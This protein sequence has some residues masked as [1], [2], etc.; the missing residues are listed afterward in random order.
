MTKILKKVQLSIIIRKLTIICLC[1]WHFSCMS[2][3][4]YV[5]LDF[6]QQRYMDAE[7]VIP[8]SSYDVLGDYYYF[9]KAPELSNVGKIALPPSK[10]C[11]VY[12]DMTK[13]YTFWSGMGR[14]A[15]RQE[16]ILCWMGFQEENTDQEQAIRDAL[17]KRYGIIMGKDGEQG[18]PAKWFT[19]FLEMVAL[20]QYRFGLWIGKHGGIYSF[21][22]GMLEE[23]QKDDIDIW[24]DFEWQHNA[25]D[26]SLYDRS[27]EFAK[28]LSGSTANMAR[29]ALLLLA[30]D[31]MLAYPQHDD[32]HEVNEEIQSLP[33]YVWMQKDGSLEMSVLGNKT[34]T[35][36]QKREMADLRQAFQKLPKFT[37][38]MTSTLHGLMPGVLLYATYS[39]L[40]WTFSETK[41][42]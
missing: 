12:G 40:R 31:I 2:A 11:V 19:G 26:K 37:F 27:Y 7:N 3:Q 4:T 21:K 23:D 9:I 5:T 30:N 35:E 33:I 10:W 17:K 14:P 25:Y 28:A 39:R 36:I 32:F 13:G 15:D 34:Y 1:S 29:I 16:G 8:I 41:E 24:K 22:K 20:P 6:V 38:G 42:Q 18:V